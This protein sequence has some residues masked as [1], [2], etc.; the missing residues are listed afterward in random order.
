LEIIKNN[1]SY[2]NLKIIM[3]SALSG[4]NSVQKFKKLADGYI[5][6][7]ELE[8]RDLVNIVNSYLMNSE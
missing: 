6:K 1:D 5:V 4:E 3:L 8:P 7:S 2:L